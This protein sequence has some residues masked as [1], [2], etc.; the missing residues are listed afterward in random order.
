M[1]SPLKVLIVDD[2]ECMRAS[3]SMILDFHGFTAETAENPQDA[4]DRMAAQRFDV[5]LTDLRMSGPEDGLL[6]VEAAKRDHP[7]ALV[8]LMS[9]FP[10]VSSTTSGVTLHSDQSVPTPIDI[11]SL[12]QKI[13]QK[14]MQQE[15]SP[16]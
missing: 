8:L 3:I 9:A 16:A 11:P 12:I 15:T 4:I 7:N 13:E 6:V 14:R 1:S 5:I 2:E 10:D